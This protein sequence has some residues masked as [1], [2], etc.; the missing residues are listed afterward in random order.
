MV[1][2]SI[3]ALCVRA[4]TISRTGPRAHRHVLVLSVPTI[5]APNPPRSAVVQGDGWVRAPIGCQACKDLQT[6]IRS[7]KPRGDRTDARASHRPCEPAYERLAVLLP[8]RRSL[9]PPGWYGDCSLAGTFQV[10]ARE[11]RAFRRRAPRSD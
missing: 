7:T 10:P 2:S 1:L 6:R 4:S 5:L 3:V 11:R 8:G 9:Q